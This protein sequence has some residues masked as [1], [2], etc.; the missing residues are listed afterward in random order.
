MLLE[1][2]V[3]VVT[4]ASSGIGREIALLF[5]AQGARVAACDLQRAPGEQLVEDLRAAKADRP[6][7]VPV[8]VRSAAEVES[9]ADAVVAEAGRIDVLV[10]CAG[11]REI[12][13]AYELPADEWENVIAVNLSGVFY[14]CQSAARRM[15]E[16][17][18]GSIINVS[19]VGGLIGLPH[20]PAY[21]A[22]KHGVVGLTRSLAGD[23][24]ADGIR[25]NAICPGL[26][27]T[28][29]TNQ[30]FEDERFEQELSLVIPQG[31]V[32]HPGRRRPD[33]A[34]PRERHGRLRH[35]N[36]PDRR[37]GLARAEELRRT[38][39]RLVLVQLGSRDE[40]LTRRHD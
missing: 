26:I 19:S 16:S 18:G 13:D 30:Y 10:N 3:A 20:R 17:G 22:S 12:G 11:V 21:T 7:F 15:R 40:H 14:W 34:L 8:D 37:R 2:R 29:L 28:P 31:R 5:A 32:G 9:A 27:R 6:F 1:G 38:G 36:R 25:V 23:L 24:A 33:C 39:R 35:R 4:G